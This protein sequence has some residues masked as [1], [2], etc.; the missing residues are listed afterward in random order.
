MKMSDVYASIKC[1]NPFQQLVEMH[2]RENFLDEGI[3]K[4]EL[5]NDGI[6]LTD[7]TGAVADFLYNY[8]TGKIDMHE[9]SR[10]EL[11]AEAKRKKTIELIQRDLLKSMK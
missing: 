3:A 10:K 5:L 9:L 1:R 6:R 7:K 11:K 4:L 8:E 2:I